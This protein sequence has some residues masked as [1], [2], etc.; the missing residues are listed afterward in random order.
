MQPQ[1]VSLICVNPYDNEIQIHFHFLSKWWQTADLNVF[2][3]DVLANAQIGS[4]LTTFNL[5]IVVKYY[6]VQFYL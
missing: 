1:A 6:S 2:N 3:C 5:I 4:N